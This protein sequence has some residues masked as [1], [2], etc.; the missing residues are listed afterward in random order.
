MSA[1]SED[2]E[3]LRAIVAAD[4]ALQAEL[5]CEKDAVSFVARTVRLAAQ[6]DLVVVEGMVWAAIEKGRASWLATCTP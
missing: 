5:A 4:E 3:R 6:H 2:F 1:E